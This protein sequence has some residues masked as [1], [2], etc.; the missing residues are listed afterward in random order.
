MNYTVE[1]KDWINPDSYPQLYQGNNLLSAMAIFR[2]Y[3][4]KG[5]DVILFIEDDNGNT[6]DVL[7]NYGQIDNIIKCN[8]LF[9]QSDDQLIKQ[10]KEALQQKEIYNQQYKDQLNKYDQLKKDNE[11]LEA[12]NR[13]LKQ[14]TNTNT[15]YWYE[16]RL[17]GFSPFCQPKGH[18]DHIESIGRHGII[19]YDRQLTTNELDEYELIP[20]NKA[21]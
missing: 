13:Q 9:P 1:L 3:H 2:Q 21:V 15:I 18:I 5:Q 8:D 10:T 4:L 12:E 20:Y 17:R 6:L 16:Y 7:E 11:R 19:A 14:Q